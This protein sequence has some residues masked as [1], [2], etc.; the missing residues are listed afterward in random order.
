MRCGSGFHIFEHAQYG[1]IIDVV[2]LPVGLHDDVLAIPWSRE[3]SANLG[4]AF[5]KLWTGQDVSVVG[6]P[7]GRTGS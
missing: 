3:V 1:P 5:D 2:A 6:Y 7:Y 4:P